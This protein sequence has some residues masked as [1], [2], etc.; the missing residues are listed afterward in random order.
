M[1][2]RKAS[3]KT[4]KACGDLHWRCALSEV[5]G[6]RWDQYVV[7][8]NYSLS[9]FNDDGENSRFTPPEPIHLDCNGCYDALKLDSALLHSPLRIGRNKAR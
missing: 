3:K 6:D 5:T 9:A 7:P 4:A 2:L 8:K 1:Q